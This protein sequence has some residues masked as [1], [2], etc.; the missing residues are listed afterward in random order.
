MR[1]R[2][3]V[4]PGAKR[5]VVTGWSEDL[6]K[7]SVAAPPIDGRANE[8]LIEFL[9]AELGLPRRQI[10]LVRGVASRLKLL[11]IDASPEIVQKWLEE[12]PRPPANSPPALS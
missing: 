9:A 2:V 1:L 4:R 3:Q 5:T 11:E 10:Q 6:L 8:A 7:I 12:F